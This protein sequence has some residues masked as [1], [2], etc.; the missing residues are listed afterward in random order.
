[1]KSFQYTITDEVG[2]HARPAGMLVKEA[3]KYASD[4]IIR[5]GGKQADARKLMVL[6]G[7]G[8]KCG[9]E[10]TV[11][12]TGEDEETACAAL[13]SFFRENL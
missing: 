11:E 1:M 4:V 3:K 10:V 6:M 5:C 8:V 7:M 12:V 13:E 2:I 9:D